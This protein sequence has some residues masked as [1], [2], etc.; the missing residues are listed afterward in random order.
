MR[1]PSRPLRG[2][3]LLLALGSIVAVMS[4][5]PAFAQAMRTVTD[6]TGREVVIPVD[7]QRI[8][9]LRG[10]QITAP[11]L[12]LGANLVAS[13][14]NVNANVNGGRPYV[15]GA[16]DILDFR[17]ETSAITWV[18][19]PNNFD[20]EA[21]A[22]AQPDL[23]I[24]PAV[25]ATTD[26]LAQLEAIAPAVL[27]VFASNDPRLTGDNSSL[28]R[29]QRIADW[30]GR[31]DRFNELRALFT[32]RIERTRAV[33][34]E[35]IGDPAAIVV[36]HL[37]KYGGPN[38]QSQRHYDMLTEVID[39]IGFSYPQIVAEVAGP[40]L[41]LSAELLPQL[42]SDFL[43][44]T[45]STLPND[46]I[47]GMRQ[48]LEDAAPGWQQFLHATQNNQWFF[49]DRELMRPTT[50]ASARYVLDVLMANIVTRAF[51]PLPSAP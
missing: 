9:S 44:S 47:A 5:Q 24:A 12:E 14:G 26:R 27:L 37:D 3:R 17:F 21:I 35:T 10:E 39:L 33:I 20:I 29:Y 16:F 38:F 22:A 11:L 19:D 36:A 31:L 40:S 32:E 6:D 43:V 23:I 48:R 2:L 25:P 13:D 46:S 28:D 45:Y 15:R 34:A 51:V 30:A 50:F 8:V 49:I 18:G 7:P 4:V 42:Q 1:F 41:S